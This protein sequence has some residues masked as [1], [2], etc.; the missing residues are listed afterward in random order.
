MLAADVAANIFHCC[1]DIVIGDE[2]EVG[3][4]VVIDAATRSRLVSRSRLFLGVF[5][6]HCR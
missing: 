5:Q 1:M 3:S 4:E 6:Y 2:V